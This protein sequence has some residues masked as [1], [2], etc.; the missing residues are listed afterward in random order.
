MTKQERR[1]FQE[2]NRVGFLMVVL[3]FIAGMFMFNGWNTIN[4]QEA[5]TGD[6][7]VTIPARPTADLV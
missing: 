7:V 4:P 3:A 5:T 2:E 1:A 6:A